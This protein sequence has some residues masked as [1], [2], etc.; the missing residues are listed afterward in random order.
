MKKKIVIP[1]C[2]CIGCACFIVGILFCLSVL[3][4]PMTQT[5]IHKNISIERNSFR[6]FLVQ[7]AIAIGTCVSIFVLFRDHFRE[8]KFK[9][10][11]E[12]KF[13]WYSIITD[14]NNPIADIIHI[15]RI[16]IENI[17]KTTAQN[18]V[19]E[20]LG[21]KDLEKNIFI[22]EIVPRKFVWADSQNIVCTTIPC[23]VETFCNFISISLDSNKRMPNDKDYKIF[24][25]LKFITENS[26]CMNKTNTLKNGKY[27]IYF[28]IA[29]DNFSPHRYT[30]EVELKFEETINPI[31]ETNPYLQY[32]PK[33]KKEIQ[34][35]NE[36][37]YINFHLLNFSEN[38]K[39]SKITKTKRIDIS[40]VSDA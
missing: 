7:M 12:Q 14:E 28:I 19:V 9:I 10:S 37:P 39:I 31:D 23:G 2:I 27:L 5:I 21:I 13:P 17:K 15:Y 26:T 22:T 40:E 34:M 4:E 3:C 6:D 18:V 33:L 11:L 25:K 29:G 16:K 30:V 35:I 1:L 24:P 8:P 36:S 38:L 32:F 20:L